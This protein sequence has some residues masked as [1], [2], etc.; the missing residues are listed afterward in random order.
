[1]QFGEDGVQGEGEGGRAERL[2][3][4]NGRPDS[5]VLCPCFTRTMSAM[6]MDDFEERRNTDDSRI[7]FLKG[8]KVKNCT[9]HINDD[10][11]FEPEEE[12]Q[13]HLGT[14]LGDHWSGAM[15]ELVTSSR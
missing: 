2:H 10:S 3:R 13:V 9:V 6:V 15:W 4:S 1:M 14:P 5:G 12:F 7:A 11:V 8:E